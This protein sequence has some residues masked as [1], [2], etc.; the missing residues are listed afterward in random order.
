MGKLT[1]RYTKSELEILS[2]CIK[3]YEQWTATER[4]AWAVE[5]CGFRQFAAKN[6]TPIEFYWPKPCEAYTSQHKPAA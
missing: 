1:R 6:I 2:E 4:K 3:P 5:C